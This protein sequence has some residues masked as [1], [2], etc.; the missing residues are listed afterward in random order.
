MCGFLLG[1]LPF[2]SSLLFPAVCR[3]LQVS[4]VPRTLNTWPHQIRVAQK[5]S[6]FHWVHYL[7]LCSPA[8]AYEKELNFIS[9]RRSLHLSLKFP[10]VN[11]TLRLPVHLLPCPSC[12]WL[13]VSRPLLRNF[14]ARVNPGTSCSQN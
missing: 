5:M 2:S 4:A 12:S 8:V 6:I 11:C 1:D 14:S 9:L 3:A 13:C 10:G 7:F